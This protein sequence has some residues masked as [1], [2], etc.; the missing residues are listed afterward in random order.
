MRAATAGPRSPSVASVPTA[1]PSCSCSAERARAFS[2]S[3]ARSSGASQ[4]TTLK[5]KLI[6]CAGCSSVRASIGVAA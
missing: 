3:R 4:A 5:P 1:P 2:R 6:T